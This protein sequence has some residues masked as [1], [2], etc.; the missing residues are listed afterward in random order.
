LKNKIRSFLSF[1]LAIVL[2]VG[3]M[4]IAAP[5]VSAGEA[6]ATIV[7]GDLN[8]DGYV[9]D[10]DVILLLWHTLLPDIYSVVG[11]ADINKD[12]SVNDD[13]VI[14]LLWHTL[15]PEQYPLFK[16]EEDET[17]DDTE[18]IVTMT[19][20]QYIE[21]S[22]A[23]QAAFRKTFDSISDFFAWY[24]AAKAEY[25][26]QNPGIDIGDGSIDL[27]DIMNNNSGSGG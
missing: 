12:G 16:E 14:Y 10:D 5:M 20:K 26:A 27:E 1:V 25:D 18:P 13:D 17:P 23:E 4:S 3:L 19:Y 22:A 15:L 7:P 11:E 21:L 9:N 24:N 6:D 2:A 8:A